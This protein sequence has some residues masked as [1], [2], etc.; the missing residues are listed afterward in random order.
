MWR[1]M[2]DQKGKNWDRQGKRTIYDDITLLHRL[3]EQLYVILREVLK[4]VVVSEL[5]FIKIN[6]GLPWMLYNVL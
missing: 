1:R 2:W 3:L 4:G 6:P 5:D